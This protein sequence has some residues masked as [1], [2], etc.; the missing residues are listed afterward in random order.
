MARSTGECDTHNPDTPLSPGLLEGKRNRT[1]NRFAHVLAAILAIACHG[2]L[3]QS[4]MS[5]R[6]ATT[7]IPAPKLNPLPRWSGRATR[8]ASSS[9][10]DRLRSRSRSSCAAAHTA[11]ARAWSWAR[12]T[13]ARKPRRSSGRRQ[14][15][16]RSGCAAGWSCHPTPFNPFATRRFCRVSIPRHA[17]RSC[18]PTCAGSGPKTWAAIPTASAAHRRCRNCSS[19]TSA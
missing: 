2:L 19:T 10:P 6:R 18:K 12:R 1:M 15:A 14:R 4:S 13:P 5:R 16:R 3:R 11:S 8:F 17:A 9:K 7:P